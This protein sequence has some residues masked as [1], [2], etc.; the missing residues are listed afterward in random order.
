MTTRR[1]GRGIRAVAAMLCAAV[2]AASAAG[3][4]AAGAGDA[5]LPDG[6]VLTVGVVGDQPGLAVLR[7]GRYEGFD[8]GVAE[9]IARDLGYARKQI[10]YRPV[11][12]ADRDSAVA[13]GDVDV[14]VGY[15][16]AGDVPS[17]VEVAGAYLDGGL[18]LLIRGDESADIAG[19]P[20][21]GGRVACTPP[22]TFAAAAL[23][24]AAP[25]VVLQERDTYAQCVTALMIG[26]AD[27]VAADGEVLAGFAAEH[28]EGWLTLVGRPYA[29]SWRGVAVRGGDTELADRIARALEAMVAD[30]T[31]DALADGLRSE[32][33]YDPGEAP[34]PMRDVGTA[35]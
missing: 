1:R 25:G 5:G 2:M 35:G 8:I 23:R 18:D 34:E 11:G 6:P 13:D 16:S 26:D 10:M 24:D 27:A 29:D 31:W 30:G 33:G 15:A 9:Y 7:S 19:A 21:M 4:S 14:M 17:G 22:N 32:T 28:G 3:C 20:S 12:I